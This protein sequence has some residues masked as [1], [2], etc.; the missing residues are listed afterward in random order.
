M[1]RNGPYLTKRTGSIRDWSIEDQ[2]HKIKVPT[3][4]INGKYDWCQ[5]SAMEPF[6]NGIERVKWVQFRES[7]HFLNL[8][9][10]EAFLKVL[11][12]FLSR[13]EV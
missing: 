2:V 8:E 5:D 9:E 10:P 3:L 11:G 4:L 6:F 7:S 1:I 13:T 12:E